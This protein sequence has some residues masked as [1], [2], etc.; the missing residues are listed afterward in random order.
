MLIRSILCLITVLFLA[1]CSNYSVKNT[2]AKS[3]TVSLPL[4]HGWHD[5]E[6]VLYITTDV[7]DQAVAKAENANYAPRLRDAVPNYPKP[8]Q[9]KTVL[10]RVYAFPNGE[11]SKSVFAS[12]PEPLGHLS[13][14]RHYSPLWLMYVVVW[15]EPSK[16][17]ELTSEEAIFVAEDQGLVTIE[18]T[19]IVLNCPIIPF[20]I[21]D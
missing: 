1:S 16:A 3:D 20:P 8:P 2:Q 21:V 13:Q 18:R 15:K 7:S 11:Q 5:G 19:D 12:V 9:V 6:A 4:L 17:K 14:D 10:E